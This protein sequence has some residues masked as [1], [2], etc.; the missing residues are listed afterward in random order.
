METKELIFAIIMVLIPSIATFW[1]F[2]SLLIQKI[3]FNK[4]GMAKC[5]VC[6]NTRPTMYYY[7]RFGVKYFH[8][9]EHINYKHKN[10][11]KRDYNDYQQINKEKSHE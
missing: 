1:I 10:P 5:S 11:E 6:G 9:E 8:C 3:Q 4:K 7:M 2:Y